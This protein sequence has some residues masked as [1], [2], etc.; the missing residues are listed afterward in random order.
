MALN[1]G[2]NF[3]Y[4]G[5]KPLDARLKYDTVAAMA[6]MADSTLYDGC[7]AYCVATDKTY[8][9]KSTNTVDTDLG[10]WREFGGTVDSAISSTSE[11]PVQNKVIK[12]ALD[13]KA[14][15][16]DG[17]VPAAQLPSFVDDVI[18]G[19]YKTEDGKFYEESTYETEITPESGKIYISVDTEIQYRWTGSAYSPLGG[20]LTLGETS[21]TAYRGDRGKAAYDISQ[22]VG[23]VAN[24]QT[25]AKNSVVAAINEVAGSVGV[26]LGETSTTAYRG[27]RGKEAYDVSQTVGSVS[28]LTTTDKSSVVAAINEVNAKQGLQ[29]G[30]TSDTA[31]RGDR[32]KTAYDFSQ[33][34]YTS[35]PEMDGTASPGSSTAWAKGDHVHPSDTTKENSFRY[36]TMPTASATNEGNIVQFI[37]TT[38]GGYTNGYFYKCVSDGESTP[39]Y[40]WS[41]VN[42][43]AGGG[44]GTEEIFVGTIDEWN[45]LTTSQKESYSLV[46]IKPREFVVGSVYT[47]NEKTFICARE[48]DDDVFALQANTS[49]ATVGYTSTSTTGDKINVNL[50]SYYTQAADWYTSDVQAIEADSYKY[51]PHWVSVS[52]ATSASYKYNDGLKAA[53][54]WTGSSAAGGNQ[55][56]AINSDGAAVSLDTAFHPQSAGLA[57]AF[58]V[59]A[60]KVI[61]GDNNVITAGT[62]DHID[63]LYTYNSETGELESIPHRITSEEMSEIVSPLPAAQRVMPVGFDERGNEYVVEKYVRADGKWKPIYRR[64]YSLEISAPANTMTE[65]LQLSSSIELMSIENAQALYSSN[66]SWY[67]APYDVNINQSNNNKL[68]FNHHTYPTGQSITLL[69]SGFGSAFSKEKFSIIY[70]KTTDTWND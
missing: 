61:I 10:R 4:Q 59:D 52:D 13:G 51:G 66:S 16:I 18:D 14:D 39:T 12:T 55:H 54:G 17:K 48:L 42:V 50:T 36:S 21:S 27:D 32:G 24:L 56:Y 57:P 64:D 3:S 62:P 30:E 19:Y 43:Q 47:L 31:Y 25:T 2:D 37:G 44:S 68:F 49:W 5:A 6:S 58:N 29:L 20:A 46:L 34:P 11:N 7:L 15:L 40:S 28:S 53:Y 65:M 23:D 60:S 33:T 63:Q 26:Q 9:W 67:V 38:G 69:N 1:I 70:T 41:N 8:Q 45:A 35:N 22:T